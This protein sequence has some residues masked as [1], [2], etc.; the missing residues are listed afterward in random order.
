MIQLK[1]GYSAAIYVKFFFNI[2]SFFL[3]NILENI[4]KTLSSDIVNPL[5]LLQH[6]KREP[7]TQ[8]LQHYN[9]FYLKFINLSDKS[10]EIQNG[11][12]KKIKFKS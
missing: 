1:I 4:L 10:S 3:G 11:D 2:V 12:G 5:Y 7:Q 6:D 8:N 9:L